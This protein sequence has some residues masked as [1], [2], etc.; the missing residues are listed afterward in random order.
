VRLALRSLALA[1][2]ARCSTDWEAAEDLFQ[3]AEQK[4]GGG[5]NDLILALH[6]QHLWSRDKEASQR[7]WQ[8][9][10]II[11]KDPAM[12]IVAQD[13]ILG[14]SDQD[15][16][17]LFTRRHGVYL[18]ARAGLSYDSNPL[19]SAVSDANPAQS[20]AQNLRF[21]GS[22]E[23]RPEFGLL[24]V[25]YI[26]T[27]NRFFSLHQSDYQEHAVDTPLGVN[28]GSDAQVFLDPFMNYRELGDRPY[29]LV[30]GTSLRGVR[31]LKD[32]T[33]Y[34]Q[35]SV[36][37]D[38]Y[39]LPELQSQQGSHIRFEMGREFLTGAWT[40][41]VGAF[42]EHLKAQSDEDSTTGTNI[43]Y[44]NN[45]AGIDSGATIRWWRLIGSMDFLMT[46]R[47][48]DRPSQYPSVPDLL[49]ISKRRT[50]LSIIAQPQ[51]TGIVNSYLRFIL[52]YR[53]TRAWSNLGSLDYLDQNY[54]DHVVG[55]FVQG[56][57]GNW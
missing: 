24:G 56:A 1:A 38:W 36:F 54:E 51:V 22:Y 10:L 50:D 43:Q 55:L 37:K 3:Q 26:L 48:D 28:V 34:A 44:S 40:I 57:W 33:L 46:G 27:R 17:D 30:V 2:L 31:L 13:Y 29:Q 49:P 7:L 52:Q 42:F 4:R 6:A 47:L 19:G 39:R 8:K 25:N 15:V 23:F 35:G 21:F 14:I 20:N 11:T 9:D 53:Y 16:A 45:Q 41:R 5:G 18:E 32:G 12:R